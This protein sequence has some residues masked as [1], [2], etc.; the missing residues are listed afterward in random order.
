[1]FSKMQTRK[2][3][4]LNYR[5]M[6][7]ISSLSCECAL[8]GFTCFVS[9]IEPKN[10]KEVLTDEFWVN[11]M[12]EDLN[13]FERNKVWTL[14]PRPSHANVIGTKWIFK[15]KTDELGNVVRNKARLVAQGYTQVEGIDFDATFAPVARIESIRLL[16]AIACFL[17]IKLHQMDIKSAFL[18]GYLNE[19]AYVEQ[20]KGFVDSSKPDY[21]YKLDKALYE[22]KEAPRAWYQ[23]LTDFVRNQFR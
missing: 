19:E 1:M 10:V 2:N 14:G 6:A 9:T 23:R 17:N 15:N 11:A 12:H 13:Q 8:S 16:L 7:S 18:N 5:D 4:R 22:L 21:V 20:P 3:E